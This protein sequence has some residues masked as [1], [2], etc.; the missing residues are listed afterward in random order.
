MGGVG[1]TNKGKTIHEI[2]MSWSLKC[3]LYEASI[4]HFKPVKKWKFPSR[5]F[6][7]SISEAQKKENLLPFSFSSAETTEYSWFEL[8]RSSA[9]K[10][11]PSYNKKLL[12]WM[13]KHTKICKNIPR[14]YWEYTEICKDILRC[15]RIYWDAMR[16]LCYVVQRV[17]PPAL[18]RLPWRADSGDRQCSCLSLCF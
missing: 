10:T 4:D 7:L 2:I 5:G 18:A 13:H 12:T 17:V 1:W 3:D 9:V 16:Y 6:T 11:T 15:A 14:I 8:R